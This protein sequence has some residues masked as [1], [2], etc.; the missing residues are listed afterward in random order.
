MKRFLACLILTALLFAALPAFAL[1]HRYPT[2]E[3]YD[4]ND[5]QKLVTFLET[6]DENGMRN[7][8]KINEN[9]DPEDPETFA[10][11]CYDPDFGG[12]F[13]SGVAWTEVDGIKHAMSFDFDCMLWDE[14]AEEPAV[15]GSLT[16][17]MDFS[18][19]TELV[20]VSVSNCRIESASFDGCSGLDTVMLYG[21]FITRIGLEGC[22]SLFEIDVSDCRLETLDLS[23]CPAL[24]Y[25][26]F[27]VNRLT[28]V[29]VG[30]KPVLEV[31]GVNDNFLESL[32]VSGCPALVALECGANRLTELDLSGCPEL[33]TLDANLNRIAE[34]D[35]NCCPELM[36]VTAGGGFLKSLDMTACANI[37]VDRIT[38]S[39]GGSFEFVHEKYYLSEDGDPDITHT[40]VFMNA[41]PDPGMAFAGWFNEAGELVIGE[42]YVVDDEVE[43]YTPIADSGTT[44]FEVRFEIMEYD[45]ND[46][47]KLR[48]FLETE[49]ENGVKN[50]EK[51]SS[52]YDPDDPSTW[53][54][55]RVYTDENGDEYE[56]YFGVL[57]DSNLAGEKTRAAFFNAEGVDVVGNADLS[58]L[59]LLYYAGFGDTCIESADFT[60]CTSVYM[61]DC[62]GAYR[63]RSLSASG[64]TGLE[65]L[66]ADGCALSELDVSGCASLA[67]L[68][69]E[70]SPLTVIDLSDCPLISLDRVEAG[71][72]GTV[73]ADLDQPDF[74][75]VIAE[76]A[77]GYIFTGWYNE[78]GELVSEEPV[79]G[80]SGEFD[81]DTW[82]II[83]PDPITLCGET[84][85]IA[86]FERMPA[87]PGDADMDGVVGIG[88]ALLVMRAALG[89]AELDPEAFCD[90]NGDSEVTLVDALMILRFVLGIYE[91]I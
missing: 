83:T 91:G 27:G 25:A 23:D 19:M 68:N 21:D 49:D 52:N 56:D 41:E 16:G 72:G 44:V 14:E 79:F 28:S 35:L 38:A 2:P 54:E 36:N 12:S 10:G 1:G 53:S 22:V 90:V 45:E 18:G 84:V 78:A 50:G 47:T 40:T 62:A 46:V 85:L 8:E 37:F 60:G 11:V 66:Y 61:I 9:Y 3:G 65:C 4:A 39:G 15:E 75:F 86:R 30:D 76:P 55:L 7:G 70:G 24:M 69:V 64:C 67:D 5:Y 32:D 71:E 59:S 51:L 20:S 73:S 88:D 63:L 33:Y 58:G 82:T 87:V 80:G 43:G 48:A 77:D 81:Y 26:F 42:S 74:A 17:D 13:N 31:L 29:T 34:L 6:A 89:L 57:W